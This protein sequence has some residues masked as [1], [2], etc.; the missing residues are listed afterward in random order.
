MFTVSRLQTPPV[1]CREYLPYRQMPRPQALAE[2]P[3]PHTTIVQYDP[4]SE[5]VPLKRHL[6]ILCNDAMAPTAVE[7]ANHVLTALTVI[8]HPALALCLMRPIKE[9]LLGALLK[10]RMEVLQRA[11]L[12]DRAACGAQVAE[13]QRALACA[14]PQGRT[15]PCR[16]LNRQQDEC[17]VIA[18]LHNRQLALALDANDLTHGAERHIPLFAIPL[19]VH[20]GDRR[21]PARQGN[22][23]IDERLSGDRH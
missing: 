12:R 21:L 19:P 6:P 7:A 10:A 18:L 20:G 4:V 9:Q 14:Y 1:V 17:A 23:R 22:R 8:E 2:V 5:L 15:W 16:R 11:A 13:P 3:R